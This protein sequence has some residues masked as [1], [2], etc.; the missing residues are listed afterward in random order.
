MQHRNSQLSATDVVRTAVHCCCR[1]ESHFVNPVSCRLLPQ[2]GSTAL[3]KAARNGH[4]W[5]VEELLLHRCD[6]GLRNQV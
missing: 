2:A 5:V 1:L 4:R 6:T 3:H